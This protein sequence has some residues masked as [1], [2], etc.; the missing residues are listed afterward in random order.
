MPSSTDRPA[1][2]LTDYDPHWLR[3]LCVCVFGVFTTIVAMTLLLPFLPLYVEQL[4]VSD[5]AAVVLWSG[6]IY[7]AAFFPPR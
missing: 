1:L 4:G 3:N 2:P 6:A 5:P 7:G